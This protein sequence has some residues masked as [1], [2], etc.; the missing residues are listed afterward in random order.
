[1]NIGFP[2]DMREYSYSRREFFWRNMR[3][4]IWLVLAITVG[5]LL[6]VFS[7]SRF[8]PGE[9]LIWGG[10]MLAYCSLVMAFFIRR[11][12][13][14]SKS[15]DLPQRFAFDDDH[16]YIATSLT[17]NRYRWEF[18]NGHREDARFI[19]IF[20]PYI[21]LALPKSIW[22]AEEL[23]AIRR[24]LKGKAMPRNRWIR[25]RDERPARPGPDGGSKA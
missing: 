21:K 22:S 18:F 13:I 24:N 7:G 6:M 15:F 11:T 17:A 12:L 9:M 25:M 23:E 2:D 14:A 10:C 1:M 20:L 3:M 4:R 19:V 16:L 5:A 8:S